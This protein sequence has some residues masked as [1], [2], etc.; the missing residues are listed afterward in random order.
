RSGSR[1]SLA[2]TSALHRAAENDVPPQI[3]KPLEKLSGSKPARFL[4]GSACG[5]RSLPSKLVG[6]VLTRAQPSYHAL[7]Q[8]PSLLKIA[9]VV[10]LVRAPTLSTRGAPSSRLSWDSAAG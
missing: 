9:F 1:Q 6:R 10:L 3:P 5:G 8:L 4:T 2:A 7:T